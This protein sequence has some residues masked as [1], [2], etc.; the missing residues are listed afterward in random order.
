[1][2]GNFGN[3]RI[4]EETQSFLVD[5]QARHLALGTVKFYGEKLV[6]FTN[7]MKN[8]GVEDMETLTA[9]KLREYILDLE[10]S[11]TPGGVHTFWRTVKAFMLWYEKEY[12]LPDWS[13]PIKKVPPPKVRWEPIEGVPMVDVLRM[14]DACDP[15]NFCG[16]RD[17]AILRTLVDTGLRR[18]EFCNLR[19]MDINLDNGEIKVMNGKGN[20]PRTVVVGPTARRDIVRYMRWRKSKDPRD[21]LWVSASGVALRADGLREILRRRAKDAH[22]EVPCPHDFRRTFALECLRNGMDLMQLMRLMGHTSTT[23]LQRYLALQTEDLVHAHSN[24]GPLDHYK[25]R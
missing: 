8:N 14:V 2:K 7:W 23:V 24:F 18:S 17:I 16:V 25:N 3:H 9:A 19:N 4:S 11:H 15:H 21:F 10:K 1:M 13:N 12:E 5:R 22:V 20:K 6:N